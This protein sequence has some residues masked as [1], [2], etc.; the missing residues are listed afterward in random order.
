VTVGILAFE[1][2]L[3][4]RDSVPLVARKQARR[5]RERCRDAAA[6]QIDA[7]AKPERI[8]V[9]P[10]LALC[11]IRVAGIEIDPEES[12]LPSSEGLQP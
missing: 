8:E 7:A 4:A 3:H 12:D 6:R 11:L 2:E 10:A 5:Q 1:D 9:R